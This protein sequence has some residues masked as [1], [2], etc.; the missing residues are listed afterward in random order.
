M[1]GQLVL[2]ADAIV[3]RDGNNKTFFHTIQLQVL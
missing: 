2:Y 3:I 1:P